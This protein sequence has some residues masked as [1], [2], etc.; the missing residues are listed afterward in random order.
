M[1]RLDSV[2]GGRDIIVFLFPIFIL[3]EKFS[4]LEEA[5]VRE[6]HGVG[7]TW[8]SKKIWAANE[9]HILGLAHL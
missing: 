1:P 6:G 3:L 8:S 2:A 4:S 9:F 7:L 5:V